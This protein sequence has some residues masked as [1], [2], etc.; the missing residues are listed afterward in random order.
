MLDGLVNFILNSVSDMG[1]TGIVILMA[2]ESSFVPFPSEVVI[3]PA[4]YLASQGHMNIYAVVVCGVLGSLVGA[5]VNYFI[6]VFA[7]RAI[8]EKYGKYIFLKPERLAKL[9]KYFNEHGEIITF[10]GRLVPGVRQYISFPAGL[11]KMNIPKFC[12]FTSFG[13]GIWVVVLAVM[14][15]L[16]G[17]NKE[18]IKSNLLPITILTLIFMTIIVCLYIYRHVKREKR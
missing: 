8:L 14:G 9:E 6:A 11:S 4:G 13:A 17:N 18:L 10:S 5:L 12:F 3:P 15:Y 1:Y 7:G 16:I 2:F